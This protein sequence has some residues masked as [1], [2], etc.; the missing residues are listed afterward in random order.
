VKITF[1]YPRF[2]KFLATNTDI[3]RGLVD[4]FLGDFTTPPS[5]GIPI[6][7]SWTP[8]DVEIELIDD[9]AG[10]PVD[11]S[12]ETDLVA[13]NCFTPQGTRAFEIADGFRAQ[14]TKV[15]MGGFFPSFMA[16]ECLKH[17]DAV[18]LGEAE[19][20]WEQIVADARTGNLKPRYVGG[21]RFDLAKMRIPR[22][23][24]FYNKNSYDWDEDLVQFTRGC[25]YNCAMCAIPAHMGSRIRFR[26]IDQVLEEMKTLKFE[27]VY[28]AD[29]T[30]FFPQRKIQEYTTELLTRLIPYNKKFFVSSTMALRTDKEFLD[31]AAKAGVCNFY[32]TMNV[33]PVSIRAIQG[34]EKERQ[35]LCDLV[36]ILEDR[37]IR[38]FGSFAMGRD[39]DD[40]SIADRIIDLYLKA[41]IHTSEFFL[42]SPYPGSVHWERLERQGRIF[43]KNWSHYNG[44]HVVAEH[45]TMSVDQL[46][47]Q[48]VKVWTEFFR[49][50]KDRHVGHFE[51]LTFQNGRTVVGKPLQRRGIRGKA[52]ITGVGILSPI[53]NNPATVTEALRTGS[54]GLAPITRFDTSHFRTAIGGEIKNFDASQSLNAAEPATFDDRYLHNAIAAARMALADAGIILDKNTIRRDIAIVLGTCN[55]G[56]LSAEEEYQWK[57]G[58]AERPFDEKMNLQA[59]LYGFGKA[60]ADSL[61]IGA[62]VWLVT[63]ACSSTTGAIGLAQLLISRGYYDCVLVGGS[64]TLCVANMA[65]F[66][67]LKATSTGRTAPFSLPAG[68]NIGEAAC[69]WVVEEMEQAI[70]RKRRCYGRIAG[71]ATTSDAYHPTSPDPRGDGVFRTL[72]NALADAGLDISAIGCINAHAT[73]TDANDRAESKGIARLIGDKAIPAVSTKSFFGHCMGTTG[74]LEAT[75]NLLAMNAGFIPPTLNFSQPRPGCTLDYVPN[76]AR[77]TAY[78]AFISANYAFGGNNAAAVITRWDFYRDH[79]P[80]AKVMQRVVVTGA[81]AVTS[82]GLGIEAT[83]KGLRAD[84]CGI[85][86]AATL[87]LVGL[88]S[89]RAGLV[90]DFKANQIDRRLDFGGM[91]KISRFA[92]A[93]ARFSL[94]AAGMRVTPSIAEK[95]GIVMG[96]C[97]GPSEMEHMD[98]VFSSDTYAADI[99]CFSNIVAN[100]TAGWVSNALALKGINMTL[101]PGHH[102]GL[103]ALA[104]AYEML[105]ESRAECVVAAAADEVYAQTFFNYDLMGFL[106]RDEAEENYRM[107]PAQLREKVL[108][109]GAAG[110]TLE[111]LAG[112]QA[113]G[114]RILAEVLGWGMAM[115]SGPFNNQNLDPAALAY[116][117][118]CA[119]D[120]ADITPDAIDLIVWAPQGNCQDEK[121]LEACRLVFG[122]RAAAIP[123]ATTTF[124]T[125]YIE[126]ASILV[127]LAAALVALQT[128]GLLWPQRTG[129]PDIDTRPVGGPIRT[130][131]ALGSSDVGYNFAAVLTRE[132]TL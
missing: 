26:P 39:W 29:D 9:N 12:I 76:Q 115:D 55:G 78:D 19:P 74:I 68:L 82:L 79:E 123:M 111:T 87:N 34:G 22:R 10:D 59:Q 28:L 91:N 120:K 132:P 14:G 80:D 4:Y 125:G 52:V 99:S 110:L 107:R 83:L 53:G 96:V 126:S 102:A 69:F 35:M 63:T 44:A 20:V 97:N 106:C 36:K 94:D 127:S 104:Y 23:D 131:L 113:R 37:G 112:A 62:E 71:H 45:P 57:H 56:L 43:D 121:S 88:K 47:G 49:L 42:F 54:H 17:C 40:T 100:S 129:V 93:A 50:Q 58:K 119:L 72:R 90:P 16:D 101:A 32:C 38:F 130:I 31:L 67:A 92:T 98:S 7:A 109:E 25:S 46:Y 61:G 41:N 122:A 2:E 8:P 27:N 51:P 60:M 85:G 13:I 64:D 118:G 84:A 128:D 77:T 48:F 103:Q 95:I 6:L 18:C 124:N 30:L 75:C 33:D 117:C 89:H 73:G 15:V 11:F 24:I 81:G 1:I 21:C 116:A 108:G 65:G 105:V 5:L 86:S 3:D 70:L 114:A 66:D